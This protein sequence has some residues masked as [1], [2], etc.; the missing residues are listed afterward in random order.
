MLALG[1]IG[2]KRICTGRALAPA[3]LRGVGASVLRFQIGDGLE[4]VRK[5]I[6]EVPRRGSEE[7]P[8]SVLLHQGFVIVCM[9]AAPAPGASPHL[10]SK[11][12][13]A[14][15]DGLLADLAGHFGERLDNFALTIALDILQRVDM[16]LSN[17]IAAKDEDATVPSAE[18]AKVLG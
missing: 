2:G 13:H 15:A 9:A 7:C 5:V 3:P 4:R 14:V 6:A 10:W 16:G 12:V 1:F 11:S 17:L 18:V 8:G